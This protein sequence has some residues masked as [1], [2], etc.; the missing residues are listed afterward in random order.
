LLWL[1][2]CRLNIALL[3]TALLLW[4]ATTALSLTLLNAS[5]LDIALRDHGFPATAATSLL[6]RIV[7]LDRALLDRLRACAAAGLGALIPLLCAA[8][9]LRRRRGG[10]SSFLTRQLASAVDHVSALAASRRAFTL[11]RGGKRRQ[12][13]E[14]STQQRRFHQLQHFSSFRADFAAFGAPLPA[15]GLESPKPRNSGA[16]RLNEG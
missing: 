12:G 14:G 10:R 1:N 2:R 13:Y 5:L 3:Q 7:R 15:V 16:F 6:L 4:R 9:L 8:P 11:C